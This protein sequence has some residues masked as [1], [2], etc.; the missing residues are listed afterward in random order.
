MSLARARL[1]DPL[2]IEIPAW[3][4]DPQGRYLGGNEMALTLDA[5]VRFGEMYRLDGRFN[6]AQ[7]LSA[8]WVRQSFEERTQSFF[9]GLGY[10]YGWFLGEGAG[11]E[12]ALARGYGGQIICVAPAIELTL[13]I[14]SDPL[15]PAR[16]GGYFGDLQRLIEQQVLPLAKSQIS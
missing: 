4:R 5:M 1:G 2:G 12:Y 13:A 16:S 14:T 3:T 11:V 9:S 15:R 10:G 8:D 7:V 6:G